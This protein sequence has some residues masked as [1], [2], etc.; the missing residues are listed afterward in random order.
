M[1][2]KNYSILLLYPPPKKYTFTI[3]GSNK[4]VNKK[5]TTARQQRIRNTFANSS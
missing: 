4:Y 1:K 5:L 3:K 2:F